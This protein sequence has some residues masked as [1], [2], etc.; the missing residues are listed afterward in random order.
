MRANEFRLGNY[1]QTDKGD[2]AVIIR[3]EQDGIMVAPI[4]EDD[5]DYHV[6][7]IPLEK[8]WVVNFGFKPNRYNDEFIKGDL[9]L[10]CEYTDYNTW[11]VVFKGQCFP[12]DLKY[13]HELQNIYYAIFGVELV[14]NK[15]G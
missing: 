7:P 9:L 3:V 5:Y 10:D 15:K 4:D 1:I 14:L 6:L 8:D 12:I 11:N 2:V 13:V